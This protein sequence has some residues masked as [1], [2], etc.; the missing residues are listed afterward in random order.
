MKATFQL[1]S[2]GEI[3]CI[4]AEIMGWYIIIKLYLQKFETRLLRRKDL[5]YTFEGLGIMVA[6]NGDPNRKTL[7]ID[8]IRRITSLCKYAELLVEFRTAVKKNYGEKL[9][10]QVMH[11]PPRIL[12]FE[13]SPLLTLAVHF[14]PLCKSKADMLILLG[15]LFFWTREVDHLLLVV[16]RR[17]KM[18][19]LMDFEYFMHLNNI[20]GFV[21]ETDPYFST[22]CTSANVM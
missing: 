13:V 10:I 2:L 5:D 17:Y 11:I 19:W 3:S 1:E 12:A 7:S 16:P 15:G 21:L 20:S 14:A 18:T 8:N 6:R 4:L 22:I 9:L